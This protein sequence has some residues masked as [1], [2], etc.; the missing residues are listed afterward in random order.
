MYST[1]WKT[2]TRTHHKMRRRNKPT[3]WWNRKTNAILCRTGW[4]SF[5]DETSNLNLFIQKIVKTSSEYDWTHRCHKKS[6]PFKSIESTSLHRIFTCMEGSLLFFLPTVNFPW[7]ARTRHD[8]AWYEIQTRKVMRR[9]PIVEFPYEPRQGREQAFHT[10][11]SLDKNTRQKP[12]QEISWWAPPLNIVK[13]LNS[14]HDPSLHMTQP[15]QGF[16]KD[17]FLRLDCN[18]FR[19]LQLSV[20]LI[21]DLAH[22]LLTILK[23]RRIIED[24]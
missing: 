9:P 12:K 23:R 21:C 22:N 8:H 3:P 2:L 11:A 15:T 5:E 19:T 24:G 1:E 4:H 17:R 18:K 16:N 7:S 6:D 14:L 20:R 13:T 10:I